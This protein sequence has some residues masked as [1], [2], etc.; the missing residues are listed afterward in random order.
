MLNKLLLITLFFNVLVYGNTIKPDTIDLLFDVSYSMQNKNLNKEFEFLQ[1]YFNEGNDVDVNLIMFSNDIVLKSVFEIRN[2]DWNELKNVIKNSIYDGATDYR[3]IDKMIKNSKSNK[4]FLFS[5]LNN[6]MYDDIN[7]EFNKKT[8]VINSTSKIDIEKLNKLKCT[9][10]DLNNVDVNTLVNENISITN[11]QNNF[12]SKSNELDEVIITHKNGKV[13]NSKGYSTTIINKHDIQFKQNILNVLI[14]KVPGLRTNPR[15]G[16]S[17]IRLRE[18]KGI[19]TPSKPPMFIVD[20]VE[21]SI[22]SLEASS[23]VNFIKKVEV[24]RGLRGTTLYGSRAFAGVILIT[25]NLGKQHHVNKKTKKRDKGI[26]IIE[27]NEEYITEYDEL[28]SEID[29]YKMY[30]KQREEYKKLPSYFI[31]IHELFNNKG[32]KIYADR[33]LS[34]ILEEEVLNT[35][36]LRTYAFLLD[37]STNY[38]LELSIWKKIVKLNPSQPQDYR[39]LALTYKKINK[40]INTFKLLNN[41]NN[42]EGV[43]YNL[44]IEINNMNVNNTSLNNEL[45][46][47]IVIDWSNKN[48]DLDLY[49][50]E[51]NKDECFLGNPNTKI[52][53][54]ISPDVS[55]LGPESYSLKKAK[56]GEYL[57]KVGYNR[58]YML[59]VDDPTFLKITIFKNYGRSNQSKE[60]KVF[61]LNGNL[62][63]YILSSIKI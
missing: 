52:G 48:T 44:N 14:G 19:Q 3:I 39:N 27:N 36:K 58:D 20:G 21:M 29:F 46:L 51:P 32:Y 10:L 55:M 53:G 42:I 28:N 25:T 5:D 26:V 4:I 22:G 6:T 62:K 33:I 16:L 40:S 49:I 60:I 38:N 34:N 57:I 59:D 47:R 1:T 24:I 41:T 37:K 15:E 9:Y 2:G 18:S 35:S 54:K 45:D 11:Q 12:I 7:F 23:I 43:I 8:I 31:D 30:L 50:I 13:N 61:R 56:K 63:S 17:G